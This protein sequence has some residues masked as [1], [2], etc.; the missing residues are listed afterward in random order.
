M[1]ITKRVLPRRTLLQ[2][3][4]LKSIAAHYVMRAAGRVA[5][6]SRQRELLG[7]L[8]AALL[9]GAPETLDPQFRV[10]FSEAT[11][12]AARHRVLIDQLAALTDASAVAWHARLCP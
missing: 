9:A 4:V 12:D 6:M 1:I 11:D 7:E 10:D 8:H 3:G 2:I 5:L